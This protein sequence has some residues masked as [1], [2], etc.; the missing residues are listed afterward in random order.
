MRSSAAFATFVLILQVVACS[1]S[2]TGTGTGTGTSGGTSGGTTTSGGTGG[3]GAGSC[4]GACAY[5]LQCKGV[6]TSD[7]RALCNQQCAVQGYTS[8]QLSDLL[9]MSCSQAIAAIDGSGGG[10]SGSSG[11]ST[12]GGSTDCQGCTWDGSSCIYLTGSGGNY[13][14]CA[15]SCC[16]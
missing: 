6:D 10:T 12:S 4:D 8:Q 9:Q 11:G 3:T 7:N 14:P 5:Y 13:F 1:S 2:A 16:P 15:R